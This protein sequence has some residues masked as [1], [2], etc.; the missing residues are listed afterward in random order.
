MENITP[1]T[2]G[3]TEVNVKAPLPKYRPWKKRLRL[4]CWTR[5]FWFTQRAFFFSRWLNH[6]VGF[7][8][9]A[10]ITK[11][12]PWFSYWKRACK[13]EAG[14]LDTFPA[15]LAGHNNENKTTK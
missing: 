1:A 8:C 15:L 3:F 14:M 6:Y 12:L 11:P 9:W 13:R 10:F 7:K 5:L 2:T 4:A